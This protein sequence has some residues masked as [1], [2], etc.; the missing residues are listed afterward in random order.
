M[1]KLPLLFLFFVFLLPSFVFAYDD[2]TTH[3]ALTEVIVDEYNKRHADAPITLEQKEFI[4]KGSILED[5]PPRWVNHLYDPVLKIGW[6]G[7]KLGNLSKD[8]A[9]TFISWG[10]DPEQ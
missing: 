8:A 10:V 4:I 6:N 3:P 9:K 5:M 7:E 1:K 2:K